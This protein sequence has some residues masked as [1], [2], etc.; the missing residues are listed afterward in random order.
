MNFNRKIS[1]FYGKFTPTFSH[2]VPSFLRK[3]AVFLTQTHGFPNQM[4][5]SLKKVVKNM[6]DRTRHCEERALHATRQSQPNRKSKIESPPLI[7]HQ[8]IL[9]SR[10]T[11]EDG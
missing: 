11:A 1:I 3:C 5:K 9:C 2:Q 4:R 8:S 6:Y 10:A 7:I